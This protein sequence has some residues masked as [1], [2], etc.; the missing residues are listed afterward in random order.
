[1]RS[2]LKADIINSDANKVGENNKRQQNNSKGNE[3]ESCCG[4][5][6]H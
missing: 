6:T 2:P 4:D 1:M 3:L 5:D